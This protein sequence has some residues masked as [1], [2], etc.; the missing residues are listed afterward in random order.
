MHRINIYTDVFGLTRVCE[1]FTNLIGTNVMTYAFTLVSVLHGFTHVQH[2]R[3]HSKLNRF[4]FL[5]FGF[6][7]II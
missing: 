4:L 3:R 7:L 6:L 5:L 1:R 2:R